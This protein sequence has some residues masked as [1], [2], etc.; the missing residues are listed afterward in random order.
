MA[1]EHRVP[2]QIAN[3]NQY[4][5]STDDRLQAVNPDTTNPYWTD[6]GLSAGEQTEWHDQRV[7]W[8]DKL[9]KDYSDPLKS[10]STVKKKVRD[11]IPDF[12]KFAKKPLDKIVLSDIAGE[13][14]ESIFHIKLERASPSHPTEKIAEECFGSIRSIKRGNAKISCRSA[15]DSSRASIPESA[16]SLQVSYII[17]ASEA[18]PV[19]DPDDAS[20]TKQLFFE[21]IFDH[22][23]GAANQGKWLIIYFRWYLS[24]YP[25]FAGDWNAMQRVV[26]G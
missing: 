18:A 11:F 25:Q 8:R 4:I 16:D 14:E 22:D 6:Y 7:L 13:D 17:V 21:S 10:T 5:N 3:F 15:E 12:S 19:I 9:Y 24:R 20:M 23:F 2:K 1:G 26:I